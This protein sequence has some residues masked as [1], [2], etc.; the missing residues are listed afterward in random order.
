MNR[1]RL[2]VI[3]GK[4]ASPRLCDTCWSGVVMRSARA[5]EDEVFCMYVN[6]GVSMDIVSCNRY[7][8]REGD[9]GSPAKA[10]ESAWVA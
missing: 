10:C 5:Q 2:H 3:E 8:E 6:R 1:T 4:S 9:P 7:V